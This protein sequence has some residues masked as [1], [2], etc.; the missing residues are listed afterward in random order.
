MVHERGYYTDPQ[1]WEHGV[2]E[3]SLIKSIL[4]L[5][6]IK[7][8]V[9]LG[10]GNGNYTRQFLANGIS[11]EGYDGNPLTEELTEGLCHVLDITYPLDL[12][13][14][15]LVFSLEVGEH[16]P[17]EFEQQFIDNCCNSSN[18]YIAC[19]WAHPGLE[20]EGHVNCQTSEYVI[21]EF[22]KR[23]FMYNEEATS[24][25]RKNNTGYLHLNSI[26]VFEK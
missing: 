25:I 11:C 12:G 23:G 22:E 9:D 10:C 7:T 24:F 21:A 2:C 1:E 6:E 14:F 16:I 13:K 5:F 19:S 17:P 20:W 8:V 26:M 4:E 3:A 15:D 18:K